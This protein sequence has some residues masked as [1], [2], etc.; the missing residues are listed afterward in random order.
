MEGGEREGNN[1]GAEEEREQ[2]IGKEGG[3]GGS[4]RKQRKNG[5]DIRTERQKW[6]KEKY[7]AFSISVLAGDQTPILHS[8]VLLGISLLKEGNQR[9]QN[10][11]GRPCEVVT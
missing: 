10:V 5:G 3:G 11:S 6:W 7:R 1:R 4:M 9:I 2:R 8:A